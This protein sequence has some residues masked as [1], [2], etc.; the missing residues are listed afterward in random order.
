M[1]FWLNPYLKKDED[2]LVKSGYRGTDGMSQNTLLLRTMGMKKAGTAFIWVDQVLTV[3]EGGTPDLTIEK[4][5]DNSD[6]MAYLDPY[7]VTNYNFSGSI[8]ALVK[9]YKRFDLAS[10]IYEKGIEYNPDDLV[11]KNYFAGMMAASKNNMEGLMVNFERVVNET[12]D[13]LLTSIVAYLYEKQYK[14]LGDKKDLEKA[15]KYWKILE[16][17]KDEKYREIGKRKI[18]NYQLGINN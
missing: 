4:I 15:V 16:N 14:K 5:K 1:L 12:R 17:S 7:F 2:V 18:N 8:L 6:E 11:L 9:I 13:D 10:E 3:G